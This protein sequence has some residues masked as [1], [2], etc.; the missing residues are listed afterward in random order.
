ML[1]NQEILDIAKRH[2]RVEAGPPHVAPVALKHSACHSDRHQLLTHM[3]VLLLNLTDMVTVVEHLLPG[4][5]EIGEA[6]YALINEA[7]RKARQ[8]LLPPGVPE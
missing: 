5:G 8:L 7:P 4:I 1:T 6:N 3:E 2:E